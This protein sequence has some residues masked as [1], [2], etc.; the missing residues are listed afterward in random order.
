MIS[1][2]A[3]FLKDFK[4]LMGILQNNFEIKQ[5]WREQNTTQDGGNRVL[6]NR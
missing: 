1:R 2:S 4:V 6:N 5:Q 3:S